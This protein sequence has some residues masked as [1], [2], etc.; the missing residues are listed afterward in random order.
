MPIDTLRTQLDFPAVDDVF[1]M[2]DDTL[3][4]PA[5]IIRDES[6][7]AAVEADIAD[8]RTI[9]TAAQAVR[10]LRYCR[11]VDP[12]FADLIELIICTGLRR[13]EALALHWDDIHLDQD[14]LDVRWTLSAIDNNKL[15]MTSPKTKKSRDWVA[16]SPRLRTT[17]TRRQ[18]QRRNTST[19][20]RKPP[21]SGLVFHRV[22][23]VRST[24]STSSTTSTTSPATPTSPAAASTTCATSPSP[25]HSPKASTWSS[26]PRPHSTP[27][28]P[29]PP[30]S[31]AT[32][33]RPPPAKPSTPSPPPSTAKRNATTTPRPPHDHPTTTSPPAHPPTHPAT[34]NPQRPV[35][36][37]GMKP[38]QS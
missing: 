31:T 30:I 36:E 25:W 6:H 5:V 24:P 29:P 38:S 12:D 32:S 20:T 14:T 8:E 13:G 4:R 11:S 23:G 27:R 19:T 2:I 17:L 22:D 9:W 16:I 10:F 18:D 34:P 33:R 21:G 1:R 37:S 35:R 7:R 3:N 15:V 26:S 28:S